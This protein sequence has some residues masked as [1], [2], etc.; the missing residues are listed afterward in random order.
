MLHD[1]FDRFHKR[2]N[3][4]LKNYDYAQPNCYF[5]TICTSGKRCIFGKPHQLSPFGSIA[6][7]VF[8][9]VPKHFLD[10]ELHKFVIMPNHIHAIVNVTK[11]GTD[12]S[13]VIGQYKA[14]VTRQIH[15]IS[16]KLPIWQ[17]SF[18]DHVVRGEQDYQ[19]IWQYIDTNPLKWQ[20]DCFYFSS[21]D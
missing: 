12:L 11:P 19:R 10:V 16:P 21:I 18:H 15:K 5:V 4:R 7:Q 6:R 2:K 13:V 9:M 3:P 20:D 14:F 8:E 1:D 17:V